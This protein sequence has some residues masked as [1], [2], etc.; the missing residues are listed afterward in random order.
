M[1]TCQKLKTE[2]F[3]KNENIVENNIKK[4][5]EYEE[6][7]EKIIEIKVETNDIEN[8]KEIYNFKN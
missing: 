5:E 6:N 8:I 7:E 2:R 4:K 1:S 3:M